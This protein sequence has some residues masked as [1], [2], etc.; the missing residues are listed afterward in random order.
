MLQVRAAVRRAQGHPVVPRDI[1]QVP[2]D[3]GGEDQA[4]I[5]TDRHGQGTGRACPW[6]RTPEI[7]NL[8]P[9]LT[10]VQAAADNGMRD[11][12]EVVAGPG[13]EDDAV[14]NRGQP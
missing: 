10:G 11:A 9:M 3:C 12:R 14:V 1:L 8:Q 13:G 5:R 4:R 2:H 7:Q 6:P